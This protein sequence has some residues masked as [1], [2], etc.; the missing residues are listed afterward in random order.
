M[1]DRG[2]DD[3]VSGRGELFPA[4]A[5]LEAVKAPASSVL[6]P[7]GQVEHFGA[8]LQTGLRAGGRRRRAVKVFAW[9]II[10]LTLG[11]FLLALV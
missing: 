6:S 3:L 8:A 11:V 9:S 5:E 2:D 1:S 4:E 10:V 7:M